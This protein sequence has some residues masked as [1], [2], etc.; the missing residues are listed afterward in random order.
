MKC[1]QMKSREQNH[2]LCNYVNTRQERHKKT[3]S[4]NFFMALQGMSKGE[5]T[6]V[7]TQI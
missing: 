3:K 7:F 5:N 2:F 1:I 6:I 4:A